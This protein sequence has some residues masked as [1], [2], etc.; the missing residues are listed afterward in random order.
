MDILK[1]GTAEWD[2]KKDV[3]LM[4]EAIKPYQ[5][6]DSEESNKM[7][8]EMKNKVLTVF[9]DHFDVFDP[10][11]ILEIWSHLGLSPNLLYDDDGLWAIEF[12]GFQSLPDKTDKW[13]LKTS[14]I[15]EDIKFKS[16]I[17]EAIR[18]A[19]MEIFN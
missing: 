19:C 12:C 7:F 11:Y 18:Y 3:L 5:E 14:F 10:L 16:T 4:M 17:R 15:V 1:T 9:Q 2:A 6:D 8:F 13:E